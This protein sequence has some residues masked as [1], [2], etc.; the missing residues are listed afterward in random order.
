MILTNA[1]VL[2]ALNTKRGHWNRWMSVSEIAAEIPGT[3][4]YKL[5]VVMAKLDHMARCNILETRTNPVTDRTEWR[6]RRRFWRRFW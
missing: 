5:G 4:I 6:T 1:A 2:A 3:S